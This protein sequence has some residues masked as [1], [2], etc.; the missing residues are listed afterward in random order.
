[1][2][3]LIS[4]DTQDGVKVTYHLDSVARDLTGSDYFNYEFTRIG[5][6]VSLDEGVNYAVVCGERTFRGEHSWMRMYVVIDESEEETS[7][8]LFARL[9]FLKDTYLSRGVYCGNEPRYTIEAMKRHE[10]LTFYDKNRSDGAC[11]EVWPTFKAKTLKATVVDREA[12]TEATLQ[13]DIE[14][15][16]HS[17]TLDPDTMAVKMNTRIVFPDELSNRVIRTAIRQSRG[18][19]CR[20]LWHVLTGLDTSNPIKAHHVRRVR[21]GNK[22]T[23]Y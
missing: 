8:S 14:A 13:R 9:I 10:G 15:M 16:L 17:D 3:H 1:M 11:R 2:N 22:Y 5:I 21:S 23:G 4:E 12:P 20:A 18:P 7:A 19:Y 6:G